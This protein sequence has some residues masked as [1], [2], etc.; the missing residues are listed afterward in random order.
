MKS[1]ICQVADLVSPDAKDL[2]I[3][4][5]EELTIRLMCYLKNCR[6]FNIRMISLAGSKCCKLGARGYIRLYD[7]FVIEVNVYR[8]GRLMEF[9]GSKSP[10]REGPAKPRAVHVRTSAF[11]N[12]ENDEASSDLGRHEE[13]ASRK[14]GGAL[15]P[16]HSYLY[17]CLAT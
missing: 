10:C 2:G 15:S 5:P 16:I 13:G 17:N 8:F 7:A 3:D 6:S 14:S 1:Q 4:M 9:K 11:A 12:T